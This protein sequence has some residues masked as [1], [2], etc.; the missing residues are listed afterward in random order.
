MEGKVG[1]RWSEVMGFRNGVLGPDFM[2]W[3]VDFNN[4][5]QKE[6]DFRED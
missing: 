2:V 3:R 5:K 4:D 1:G 6:K